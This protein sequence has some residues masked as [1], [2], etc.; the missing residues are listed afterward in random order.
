[1]PLY[2]PLPPGHTSSSVPLLFKPS[3]FLFLSSDTLL[4]FFFFQPPVPNT[5]WQVDTGGVKRGASDP[6]G[7]CT[8]QMK[9][10]QRFNNVKDTHTHTHKRRMH[11]DIWEEGFQHVGA[12]V[13]GVEE[14]QLRLLQ[15]ARGETLLDV[16]VLTLRQKQAGN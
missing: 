1:M 12:G 14:H 9:Q 4:N 3:A 13:A 5:H 15:M 7:R 11:L 6:A 2:L 10:Q 8:H 16:H